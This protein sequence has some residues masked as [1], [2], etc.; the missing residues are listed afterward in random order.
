MENWKLYDLYIVWNDCG[1]IALLD[2]NIVN[3]KPILEP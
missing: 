2:H 3:V 1:M